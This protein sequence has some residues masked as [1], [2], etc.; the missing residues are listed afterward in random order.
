M[1]MGLDFIKNQDF[2][3]QLMKGE[4]DE[5]IFSCGWPGRW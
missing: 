4:K 1:A 2:V 5:K 3:S